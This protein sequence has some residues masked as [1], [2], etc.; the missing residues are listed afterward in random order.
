MNGA[1]VAIGFS[2]SNGIVSRVI[3][4]FTKSK[5]SHAWVSFDSK[6]L[7]LRLI[8]HATGG[9]Y[10]LNHWEKWA[11]K[12][13]VVAQFVSREDFTDGVR[14]MA[15]QLGK[16]YDL[17]SALFLGFKRWVGKLFRNPVRNKD[18]LHCSEAITL[19]L[20]THGYA[21]NID[22]E[23]STPGDLYQYCLKEDAFIEA[24]VAGE[25]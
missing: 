10:R 4:W 21:A 20:Q 14:L 2:T 9:G 18:R 23:S 17:W 13:K 7:G 25:A 5:V 22:P 19:L 24:P 6:T 16:K 8:M 11:A 3:R 12:N 15:R 1:N